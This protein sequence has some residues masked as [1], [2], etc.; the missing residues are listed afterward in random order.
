[1]PIRRG[2][3][4]RSEGECESMSTTAMWL[5]LAAVI[6]AIL[7][8]SV[9][10][11]R[12]FTVHELALTGV[13]AAL[14]LVAYLFFRLPFYGG[15][16][17]HLG[18]TFTALTAL[19]LDGVSGGL[20]GAIGLALADILAG[21]P[22]YAVT[23]FVL[24]FLIGI[25]CGAVAHKLLHLRAQD[26]HSKGYLLKVSAAAG[27]GLLLNV[28][29]D[30]LLGYFRN[31]YIFGQQYTVAQ[32]L[33]KVAGGV[34]LVRCGALPGAAPCPGACQP[35]AQAQK[36]SALLRLQNNKYSDPFD[37]WRVSAGHFFASAPAAGITAAPSSYA[38]HEVLNDWGGMGIVCG[39]IK[40]KKPKNT[41]S[42]R[43]VLRTGGM[44]RPAGAVHQ[45]AHRHR[46]GQRIRKGRERTGH[47]D[48]VHRLWT[49]G[50]RCLHHRRQG[51]DPPQVG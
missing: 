44:Q 40:P 30:P 43:Y 17:F 31:V 13:M 29:T 27:S 46:R 15:S 36:L 33:S 23:T 14:S 51:Q 18:N 4:K 3:V 48:L 38:V 26:P 28:F 9:L 16:S 6:I 47:P 32:A 22:G 11:K 7:F 10:Y 25:C 5:L 12:R 20:A 35:A 34:T 45:R 8:F 1:M 41:G 42:G 19:L 50:G 37:G 2:K 24:K 21:D 49:G 39:H